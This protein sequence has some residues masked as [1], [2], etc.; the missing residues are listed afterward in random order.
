L[1]C[2]TLACPDSPEEERMGEWGRFEW[3]DRKNLQNLTKHGLPLVAAA[4]LFED[5]D[6]VDGDS[7]TGLTT[8]RRRL[9]IGR[10]SRP[11]DNLCLRLA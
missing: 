1:T 10:V 8:E 11:A 6:V 9:A 5:P 2:A 7:K 3:D 4:A